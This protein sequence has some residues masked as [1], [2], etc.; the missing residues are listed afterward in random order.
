LDL[1]LPLLVPASNEN[2]PYS[3]SIGNL[4]QSLINNNSNSKD[5]VSPS[6]D[7]KAVKSG[8]D[9]IPSYDTYTIEG[10]FVGQKRVMMY[11][12]SYSDDPEVAHRS[13]RPNL[14][15]SLGGI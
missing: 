14:G 13:K 5:A 7:N 2:F 11:E 3:S 1:V 6:R 12:S 8:R 9:S 10:P 15:L 4:T